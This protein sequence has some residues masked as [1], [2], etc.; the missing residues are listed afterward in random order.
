MTDAEDDN[1]KMDTK[2]KQEL[3][4]VK[5]NLWRRYRDKGKQI[6]APT[7]SRNIPEGQETDRQDRP[8]A[9]NN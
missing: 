4:E 1:V 6:L 9:Y 7:R 3:A 8:E 2:S 5:Q